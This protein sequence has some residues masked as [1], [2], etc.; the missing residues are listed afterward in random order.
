MHSKSGYREIV[1]IFSKTERSP[2]K[3]GDLPQNRENWKPEA[4]VVFPSIRLVQ[5]L[6]LVH[7]VESSVGLTMGAMGHK[8]GAPGQTISLRQRELVVGC[9]APHGTY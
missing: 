3:S 9:T 5:R 1:I 6:A 2:A 8:P 7:V 4:S